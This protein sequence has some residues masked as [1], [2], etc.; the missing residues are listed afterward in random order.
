MA[1]IGWEQLEDF[2]NPQNAD[3]MNSL[4]EEYPEFFHE[5]SRQAYEDFGIPYYKNTYPI[6]MMDQLVEAVTEHREEILSEEQQWIKVI[7]QKQVSFEKFKTQMLRHGYEIQFGKG[8]H[9][10]LVRIEDAPL[11]PTPVRPDRVHGLVRSHPRPHVLSVYVKRAY[12]AFG[13]E[14]LNRDR[15]DEMT[16]EWF[17]DKGMIRGEINKHLTDL[18]Y[19]KLMELDEDRREH[20]IGEIEK[21]HMSKRIL[22]ELTFSQEEDQLVDTPPDQSQLS[23]EEESVSMGGGAAATALIDHE[24]MIREI[25]ISISPELQGK[26]RAHTYSTVNMLIIGGNIPIQISYR[27]TGNPNEMRF[28]SDQQL[29]SELE[30]VETLEDLRGVLTRR[31]YLPEIVEPIMEEVKT[32]M[33]NIDKIMTN[34]NI[35]EL[36]PGIIERIVPVLRFF[37]RDINFHPINERLLLHDEMVEMLYDHYTKIIEMRRQMTST[38]STTLFKDFLHQKID[39]GSGGSA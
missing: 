26:L 29:V 13:Y 27:N 20:M 15:G 38:E 32:I 16:V 25:R 18:F 6:F 10:S 36:K 2:E 24:E 22:D 35:V 30:K 21:V 5:F 17:M 23:L 3:L 9:F 11:D 7:Q 1:E 33:I 28:T 4:F 31:R 8:S 34:P 14:T 39:A 12:Q 37:P 19:S